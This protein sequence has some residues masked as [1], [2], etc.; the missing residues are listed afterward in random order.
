[1]GS[2]A[3]QESKSAFPLREALRD[4]Q[5]SHSLATFFAQ[6]KFLVDEADGS[7]RIGPEF[8]MES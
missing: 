3:K 2:E 6:A 4:F 8:G 7:I 5:R 1:M